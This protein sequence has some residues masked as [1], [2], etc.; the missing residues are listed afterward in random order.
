MKVT[1]FF[2]IVK[3]LGQIERSRTATCSLLKGVLFNESSDKDLDANCDR[4][5]V[6][7]SESVSGGYCLASM[8]G[9][10]Y[11]RAGSINPIVDM[12]TQLSS[13]FGSSPII[14][15]SN[16][17]GTMFV[18]RY[19]AYRD[20]PVRNKWT[21]PCYLLNSIYRSVCF[22][23]G[24]FGVISEECYSET[25]NVMSAATN[26]VYG[27]LTNANGGPLGAVAS[28]SS[29][30]FSFLS[31]LPIPPSQA[32]FLAFWATAAHWNTR[33]QVFS[34][35][36]AAYS[37]IDPV[38]AREG[39]EDYN[40]GFDTW[41]SRGM[42][43]KNRF[44][45]YSNASVYTVASISANTPSAISLIPFSFAGKEWDGSG[46]RSMLPT[47]LKI[48]GLL[49]SYVMVQMLKNRHTVVTN[50]WKATCNGRGCPL[51]DGGF[52]D[53]GP[54][55][56]VLASA[57]AADPS[58]MPRQLA[59]LGP[60]STM[61]TVEYLMGIGSLNLESGA[62][63][64]FCPFTQVSV[65]KM[66][67]STR[68]LLVPMLDDDMRRDWNNIASHYQVYKP[69]AQALKPFCADPLIYDHF[70]GMC[71]GDSFCH[72]A[73]N[74]VPSRFNEIRITI[75]SF[76]FVLSML[77]LAPTSI[78]SRFVLE[79]I[80]DAM[81]KMKYYENMELWF[82]DFV[83]V[84]PQKGGPGFTKVAGHSL[85]DYL[86]YIVQRLLATEIRIRLEA[87]ELAEGVLPACGYR[88]FDRSRNFDEFGTNLAKR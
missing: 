51:L 26:M 57:S 50:D 41:L 14:T 40:Y 31:S 20:T 42:E 8:T 24:N 87:W 77:W 18:V 80:P 84:A 65:C 67:T 1:V 37:L 35:W 85:L 22:F 55:T 17:G 56:P 48:T 79:Y 3:S 29:V 70:R 59:L 47:V 38:E 13:S 32:N 7:Q 15:G 71:E 34:G 2:L 46:D 60:I 76:L 54:I 58:L 44:Q 10:G 66:I 43:G 9:A 49:L 27:Q 28:Y 4:L 21:F 36:T 12:L 83:I 16:S 53:N 64:N 78:A 39:R 45:W 25:M 82:P 61:F 52:T 33:L 30:Y 74:A 69:N 86:T 73:S 72:M 6:T 19:F 23:H 88:V 63:V 75:N 5:M 68:E 62:G 11:Y 81:R